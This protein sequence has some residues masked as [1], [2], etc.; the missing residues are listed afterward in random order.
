[1]SSIE[2]AFSGSTKYQDSLSGSTV[3]RSMKPVDENFTCKNS[4]SNSSNLLDSSKYKLM[5]NAVQPM[6]SSP[7]YME[8]LE[9]FTRIAVI[10]I[11]TKLHESV[12]I[13]FV[14]SKEYVKKIS[15]LPRTKQS[16]LIEI[17]ELEKGIS[18]IEFLEYVKTSESLYVGECSITFKK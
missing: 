7:L 1:M 9:V 8:K 11:P 6:H 4:Q 16:C 10:K 14:A 5:E 18:K 12:P 2:K 3:W 17:L 15:V 13:I